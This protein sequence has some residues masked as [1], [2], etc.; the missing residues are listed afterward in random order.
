MKRTIFAGLI[1]AVAGAGLMAQQA[2]QH[3]GP[4]PKSK[5]EQDALM[6]LFNSQ[7]DPDAT[8][9]N[10]EDLLSKY[11]DTDFKDTALMMEAHAYQAK[12]DDDRAQVFA[13]KALD[14]NPKNFQ[15]SLLLGE[16]TAQHIREN[17]LNK[18]EELTKAEKYLNQTIDT[19]KTAEKPN[20]QLT[21]EQ[22][23]G[24]KKQLTA[25]AES[26]LGI[27]A[28]DRKKYDD[29]V[30]DFKSASETDPQEPVYV[31]RLASAYQQSHK[32]DEAIAAAD[33]ALAMPNLNPQV[34]Q[35]A[36]GIKAEAT[37]AKDS[38]GKQ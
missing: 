15:A 8:I 2:Q 13:E 26:G 32:Y 18:E 38:G 19:L 34:K 30:A 1:A 3:R 28:L 31:V 7:N 16:S 21:D 37:K 27:C 6:A 20:P 25:Q 17:D 24:F 22:W 11:K 5:G 9:K 12:R 35:A 33:K 4:A 14:A 29:A 23:D 10:A 36:M